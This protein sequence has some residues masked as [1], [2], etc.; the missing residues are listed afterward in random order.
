MIN[1]TRA[2]REAK[3]LFRLCRVNDS[4]DENR[5]RRVV[6]HVVTAGCREGP[7]VL[8]HFVRL[9]RLDRAQHTANVES[10]TLLPADLRSAVE[11]SLKRR[12]GAALTTAFTHRPSLIGGIR[13]QV[14]CDVYDSSVQAKL[15][16]LG[17]SF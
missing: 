12:Y 14:G 7:A 3:Q 11:A 16:A 2:K 15:E 17:K 10:A 13:I 1:N 4:L 8:G 9:V 6:Q 5:V